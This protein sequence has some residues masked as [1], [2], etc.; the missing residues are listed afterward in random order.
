MSLQSCRESLAKDC[1][2]IATALEIIGASEGR[3]PEPDRAVRVEDGT[4]IYW[5]ADDKSTYAYAT[6]DDEGVSW[7][8]IRKGAPAM[9]RG[10]L[11]L[12][13]GIEAVYR[14][15]GGAL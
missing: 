14:H 13:E 8:L 9:H 5:F 15:V 1:Q 7:V 6:I 3:T 11:G 12:P 4:D 2:I 10:V